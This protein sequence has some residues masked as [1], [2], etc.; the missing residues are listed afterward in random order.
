MINRP[1]LNEELLYQQIKEKL[2][3]LGLLVIKVQPVKIHEFKIKE[4]KYYYIRANI[5]P[6]IMKMLDLYGKTVIT[7]IAIF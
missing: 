2:N 7:I 1:N 3:E 6:E 5:S 4:K